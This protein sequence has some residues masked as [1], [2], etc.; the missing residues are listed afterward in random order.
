MWDVFISHASEDKDMLVRPL[1]KQLSEIYKV[2]VWYD[3]YTLEYGDSLL[4]SIEQGLQSSEFGIVIFSKDFFK[5]TWTDHEFKSLKT[6]EMLLNKKVI[7]P[8]WYNI[9]REEVSSYSLTLADKMAITLGENFDIDEIAV[10]IIKTIRPDIYNNITRMCTYERLL[11]RSQKAIISVNDIT[12][13]TKSPIRHEKLSTSMKARLKLIYNAIKDVDDR[14]YEEYEKD[15]RRN[16]N[17][18][19]EI[20]ITELITAAYVDCISK[21]QLT[22]D[23]KSYVYIITLS[24]GEVSNIEIPLNENDIKEYTS[25]TKGYIEDINANITMEFRFKD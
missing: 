24:L 11:K 21:K 22:F 15:F 4:D 13:I 8:I 1:A 16:E 17:I 19:R 2:N 9:T 6:K 23:E 25:I 5:K 14:S 10:K 3:E 18:D 20:I 7:I 12:N